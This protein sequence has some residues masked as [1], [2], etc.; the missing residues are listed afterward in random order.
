MTP[1]SLADLSTIVGVSNSMDISFDDAIGTVHTNQAYCGPR[2]FLM[3]PKPDFAI[4]S[5]NTLTINPT[6]VSDASTHDVTLT[7]GLVNYTAIQTIEV[8]FKIIVTCQ[9]TILAFSAPPPSLIT[10]KVGIDTQPSFTNFAVTKTPNCP[11]AVTFA[12]SGTPPGF[13]SLQNMLNASGDIQVTGATIANHDSYQ[14]ILSA[15]VDS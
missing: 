1:L 9:V 10:I 15:S 14:L 4:I 12:F 6:L 13:V 11:Q 7:V 8:S 2:S 3:T 5:G